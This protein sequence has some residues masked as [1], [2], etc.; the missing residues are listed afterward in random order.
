VA[1]PKNV[2]GKK[3]KG[4][5]SLPAGEY[6]FTGAYSPDSKGKKGKK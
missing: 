3:G 6:K 1:K 4:F 5:P 2:Q